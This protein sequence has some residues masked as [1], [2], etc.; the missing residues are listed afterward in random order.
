MRCLAAAVLFVLVPFAACDRFP[1]GHIHRTLYDQRLSHLAFHSGSLKPALARLVSDPPRAT[2]SSVA[3]VGVEW[4]AEVVDLAEV[5]YHVYAFEPV[6]KFVTHLEATL[7]ENPHLNVTLLPIAAVAE[8]NAGNITLEYG[9]AGVKEEVR[10]GVVDDF[11]EGELAVLSVDVQGSEL[12][13]LKGA[14]RLLGG[15]KPAVRSMV[16]LP[17]PRPVMFLAPDI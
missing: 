14:K 9:N 10:T 15:P 2:A 7:K 4:G 12:E 17:I 13:V 16:C 6:G 3:V 11:V 8:R 5:G 1:R